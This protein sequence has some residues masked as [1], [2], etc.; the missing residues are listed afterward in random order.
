MFARSVPCVKDGWFRD[1]HG[2]IIYHWLEGGAT[3]NGWMQRPM[4]TGQRVIRSLRS[5]PYFSRNPLLS[6]CFRSI[7]TE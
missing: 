5:L 2:W 6:L 1:S 7:V 4:T 3:K